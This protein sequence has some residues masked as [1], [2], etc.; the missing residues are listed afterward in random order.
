MKDCLY[1][2]KNSK[3]SYTYDEFR[4]YLLRNNAWWASTAKEFAPAVLAYKESL[5]QAPEG[6]VAAA[7]E[8]AAKPAAKPASGKKLADN[9]V[10]LSKAT[11]RIKAGFDAITKAMG[12]S[13]KV[14]FLSESEAR[15]MLA[16]RND[17]QKLIAGYGMTKQDL[18]AALK[19]G[20]ANELEA[21]GVA[22]LDIKLQTGW[23]RGADGDWRFEIGDAKIKKSAINKII[24]NN[25][26][27]FDDLAAAEENPEQFQT[28]FKLRELID[29]KGDFLKKYP[30]AKDIDVIVHPLSGEEEAME[31][32]TYNPENNEINI[33]LSGSEV[34]EINFDEIEEAL[35]HEIQ[36]YIQIAENF[37]TGGSP[38]MFL[39]ASERGA[40]MNS[41]IL[42][43]KLYEHLAGEVEAR[44]VETRRKLSAA[45]KLQ[46]LLE[47][48]EKIPRINQIV[49]RNVGVIGE[50]VD[51]IIDENGQVRGGSIADI[52]DRLSKQ[53]WKDWDSDYT[54][55]DYLKTPDGKVLGFVAKEKD[56]TYKI[57]I[58]PTAVGSE[59]PIHEIAGHIF[60]PM[61]EEIA[62]DLYNRGVELVKG[63]EY[64]TKLKGLGYKF[65]T[66]K[67]TAA[68]A[69]A[70]AIG[71][72][73]AQLKL[74]AKD[75]FVKWLKS[76]WQKVGDIL[77]INITPEKLQAMTLGEF[78]DFIAGSIVY[79]QE[80]SEM[81]A[82]P[83]VAAPSN[84][85]MT[86][87]TASQLIDDKLTTLYEEGITNNPD[88]L[89]G[90]DAYRAQAAGKI[91]KSGN[92][93]LES[94]KDD[95]KEYLT[96]GAVG[97]Q[98]YTGA[99]K[100]FIK[101]IGDEIKK[102]AI[103]AV[104]A[105]S[106]IIGVMKATAS[107]NFTAAANSIKT[108]LVNLGVMSKFVANESTATITT[109]LS[110]AYQQSE[111]QSSKESNPFEPA[112]ALF[113][114][115]AIPFATRKKILDAIRGKDAETAKEAALNILQED[116][117]SEDEINPLMAQ[118]DERYEAK[119]EAEH[120]ADHITR[121][122][123]AQ[124]LTPAQAKQLMHHFRNFLQSEQD[125]DEAIEF[126]NNL[127]QKKNMMEK[128]AIAKTAFLKVK[129]LR[130]SK[131][132]TAFDREIAR[133]LA[134]PRF[135]LLDESELD[136][137]AAM[138][139]DFYNSRLS[140]QKPKYT[141]EQMME[142]FDKLAEKK[143]KK[144]T[145][146]GTRKTR[147]D[148]MSMLQFKVQQA[149]GDFASKI[150]FAAQLKGMDLSVIGKDKDT[151][152]R[153]LNALKAFD[154][155]GVVYDLGNIVETVRALNEAKKLRSS[156]IISDLRRLAPGAI[157]AKLQFEGINADEVRR[158]LF[159]G[160]DRNA[161]RVTAEN[162]KQRLDIDVKFDK[163][164][165][166]L[167]ERFLLGAYSFFKESSGNQSSK[168]KAS[169]LA[170]QMNE[171]K[172][173][174]FNAK[175]F[176]SNSETVDSFTHYYNGATAAL[177]QLGI[178]KMVNGQWV[179]NPGFETGDFGLAQIESSVPDN[180]K[181]A[182]GY[183]REI[184]SQKHEAY[185]EAMQAYHGRD[186]DE[187]ESY[188][189]RTFIR[190][191]ERTSGLQDTST[192][193]PE[194]GNLGEEG[195][196]QNKEVAAR[197]KG[198]S[199]MPNSGGFYVLDGYETLVNGL[200]DINATTNLSKDYAYTNALINKTT[201]LENQETN[202]ALKQYAV[203]SVKGILRDPLLFV[204]TRGNFDKAVSVAMD[205]ATSTILNNFQQLLKQP[206]A[207]LQGFRTNPKASFQAVKL[208][209][210]AINNPELKEALN[211]FFNNTSE[212]YTSQLA[213]IE[214]ETA[215][216]V[217]PNKYVKS[218][219]NALEFLNP[220][221][222]IAANRFTQRVLLLSEYLAE[223]GYT[224]NPM[225]IMDDAVNGFD[226]TALA[227]AENNAEAANSTANR[228]FLPMELKDAKGMKKFLYFLGTYTFVAANTFFNNVNIWR[229]PGY[230]EYQKK[231]AL[232]QATGFIIQQIMF[233]VMLKSLSEGLKGIGRELDWLEEEDPEKKQE[234]REKYWYQIPSQTFFDIAT[235][236]LPSFWSGTIQLGAN[237]FIEM[238]QDGFSTEET[239]GEKVEAIYK[240]SSEYPGAVG[241]IAPVIENIIKAYKT[242]DQ[243]YIG[244]SLGQAL[245][246]A[247]KLGDAYFILKMKAQAVKSVLSAE[248]NEEVF[249][250]MRIES[251][252]Q[253]KSYVDE[254]R[255][256]GVPDAVLHYMAWKEGDTGYYI[257][258]SDAEEFH[259]EY[260]KYYEEEYEYLKKRGNISSELKLKQAARNAAGMRAA[261]EFDT[262][263]IEMPEK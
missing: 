78:A 185:L 226:E 63:S 134:A 154:E 200:W 204:D 203:S 254:V 196:R 34:S 142:V 183:S 219:N 10:V 28:I 257:P 86:P 238:M 143:P 138:A 83:V 263:E 170:N 42:S 194:L 16:T 96:K 40:G 253:Y 243:Q 107:N 242:G 18:Q 100:E 54:E 62:P 110:K 73:G 19:F 193:L 239:V 164:N 133:K 61:L 179:A 20:I 76:M 256:A 223:R 85:T 221:S 222:L 213:H 174:I 157:S 4:G 192:Q 246:M 202:T 230:T 32:A 168:I 262:V 173:R 31:L 106:G 218:V 152:T 258:S 24:A 131:K 59:T 23:E 98:K 233:Q 95:I 103:I 99:A 186:Y 55:Y 101:T 117:I 182:W 70:Q 228:H 144:T 118:I 208:L 12:L 57:Y 198:R 35:N 93:V 237:A 244:L 151:L 197:N 207:T 58:D 177:S 102:S 146:S 5:A 241:V 74:S 53:N 47:S 33:Y 240:K 45:E 181:Q 236:W 50:G 129:S 88:M 250:Q 7:V 120:L 136:I 211:K 140:E 108:E 150:P 30:N 132:L 22:P 82:S 249:K 178:L 127:A 126:V 65:K 75:K 79:G 14:Q 3:K 69:L 229:S 232:Q 125:L 48:S 9:K 29:Q 189:P 214:L 209:A 71:D 210:Q 36:H 116:N 104:I 25:E 153:I 8:T 195:V 60:L 64:E 160:W 248:G 44:N 247:M 252:S 84:T 187:I 68:E 38:S 39:L 148:T 66:K 13:P 188:W 199:L 123:A 190:T 162:N 105:A 124:K 139:K 191:A 227:A 11:Q 159:G 217:Q 92:S 165:I 94:L 49:V 261:R 122:R 171:L 205:A 180:V 80:I 41:L 72:R 141:K 67:E 216:R 201:L 175:N 225:K 15:K 166:G 231:V 234:R 119:T 97:I 172:N 109:Q 52:E 37:A 158:I 147:K 245:A 161:A 206:I 156:P 115:L 130:N 81:E 135:Y 255:R 137:A 163:L 220:K 17:L 235:G 2:P 6:A 46:T 91:A 27:I 169:V 56:G 224:D 26:A 51:F 251:P 260:K 43:I 77:K 87:E 176:G 121:M 21:K 111:N 215:Y 212:P 149:L 1:T 145:Q 89:R 184:L 155:T 259:K 90:R 113:F 112:Q 167:A 114:G 128:L